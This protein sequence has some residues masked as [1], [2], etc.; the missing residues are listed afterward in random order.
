MK[1][2]SI[3]SGS[4]PIITSRRAVS[5]RLMP[6]SINSRTC[7][8]LM[9][10]VFPRLPLPSTD[11]V[12]IHCTM[13]DAADK[14]GHRVKIRGNGK[15][16]DRACHG[17]AR[18]DTGIGSDGDRELSGRNQVG[19][20]RVRLQYTQISQRNTAEGSRISAR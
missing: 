15:I 2:A 20:N 8:V 1:T 14:T 13:F 19:R 16:F 17:P 5:L 12:T 18:S 6:A 3:P 11:T 4:S 7:S 9:K 10:V